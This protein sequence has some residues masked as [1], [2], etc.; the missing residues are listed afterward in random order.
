[1]SIG[2]HRS[3]AEFAYDA[4]E[5]SHVYAVFIDGN[6]VGTVAHCPATREWL[7][8]RAKD[9]KLW[10][11]CARTRLAAVANGLAKPAT[12]E[13]D[14]M[15][16]THEVYVEPA[17][18]EPSPCD[19]ACRFDDKHHCV[20]CGREPN[21]RRWSK[22]EWAAHFARKRQS[23]PE[24]ALG[25]LENRERQ[26]LDPTGNFPGRTLDELRGAF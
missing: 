16:G 6:Y 22:E 12:T 18:A 5:I 4:G 10:I 17:V 2:I 25:W 24:H 8:R 7:C 3:R 26:Q 19:P 11:G 15:Y 13:S 21:W 14:T 20:D 9:G 23:L 1:M